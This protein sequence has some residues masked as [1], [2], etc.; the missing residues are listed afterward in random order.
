[1][2][3]RSLKDRRQFDDPLGE[4]EDLGISSAQWP[5]FGMMWDSAEILAQHMEHH[6]IK[7]KRILEVGCGLGLASL[8]LQSRSADITAT[9]YHPET[10]NFLIENSHLNKLKDIPFIRC[11]WSGTDDAL[12][13]FDLIIGSD[14]LYE[15]PHA[16][17]LANF[18]N[19][20]ANPSCTILLIDPGRG[21]HSH[22]SKHMA[23]FGYT[24]NASRFCKPDYTGDY[25][26]VLLNYMRSLS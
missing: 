3:I 2:H 4:A 20:H 14:V 8:V 19:R 18:I 7:D 23:E 11:D 25:K 13:T 16:S 12:G 9:D 10:E 17:M 15:R 21:N 26:G 24:L 6:I 5:I 22:F 1:M